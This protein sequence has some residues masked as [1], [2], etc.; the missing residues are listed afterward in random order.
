M[1]ELSFSQQDVNALGKQLERAKKELG[2]TP[3]QAVSWAANNLARSLAASTKVSAKTRPIVKNPHPDAATDNRRANFGVMKFNRAGEQV[4]S[5]IYRTGEF[6]KFR[7]FDKKS[8]SWFE[9]DRGTG[10]AEWR[11]IASGADQ[12][13]PE[14]VV[15]GIMADNRR[16]IGRSGLAK[17][18]WQWAAKRIAWGGTVYMMGVPNVASVTIKKT[19]I[20]YAVTIQNNLRYAAEAFKG[21][22]QDVNTA[23]IRAAQGM[24]KKIDDAIKKALKR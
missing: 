2:K 22:R 9:R 5:P 16:K 12:A 19:A 4:F 15:P 24:E 20:S 8:F 17:K 18:T 1:V 11:K 14:I 10:N 3:R 21:G 7:F 6:G 23:A 13:N